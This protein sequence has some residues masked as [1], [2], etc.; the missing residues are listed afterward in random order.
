MTTNE[1]QFKFTRMVW[2]FLQ[3]AEN[4][5]LDLS[6]RELFRSKARQVK[7]KALGKSKTFNSKHLDSLALDV[8]LFRNGQPVWDSDDKDLVK[9]GEFWESLGGTWGGRWGWDGCHFEYKD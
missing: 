3:F 9:L 8:V 7:L 6:A 4:N 1:K 5:N 2:R